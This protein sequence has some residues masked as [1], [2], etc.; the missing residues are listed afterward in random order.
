[1]VH[2]SCNTVLFTSILTLSI[3]YHSS[4]YHLSFICL[5]SIIS[6]SIVYHLLSLCLLTI[7][8]AFLSV[9]LKHRFWHH[10]NCTWEHQKVKIL[11]WIVWIDLIKSKNF[12]N[13]FVQ[14]IK[15]NLLVFSLFG[16]RIL[17]HGL[18]YVGCTYVNIYSTITLLQTFLD[19]NETEALRMQNHHCFEHTRVFSKLSSVFL[20]LMQP[21][22]NENAGVC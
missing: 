20:S 2:Q 12:L 4:V 13:F 5:L 22:Q 11:D 14:L 17:R 21:H 1:M 19:S 8:S 6:V 10:S 16:L 7:I 18:T 15:F 3:V 9:I